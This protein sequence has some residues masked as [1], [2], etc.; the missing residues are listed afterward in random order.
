MI[1]PL[2]ASVA[3]LGVTGPGAAHVSH[4]VESLVVSDDAVEVMAVPDSIRLALAQHSHRAAALI[5]HEVEEAAV[6][7]TL[8]RHHRHGRLE[9]LVYDAHGHLTARVRVA[10]H[11]GRLD[12]AGLARLRRSLMPAI[13]HLTGHAAVVND[14]G[15]PSRSPAP[16]RP[17]APVAARGRAARAA[18][19]TAS[20][21]APPTPSANSGPDDSHDDADRDRDR[22][23]GQDN[24]PSN[25][26][27]NSDSD[28]DDDDTDASLGDDSPR[29]ASAP[30]MVAAVNL[31]LGVAS[32]SFAPGPA[33]VSAYSGGAVAMSRLE[34]E[35]RPAPRFGLRFL[36][37]HAFDFATAMPDGQSANTTLSRWQAAATVRLPLG[38]VA[39]EGLAGLGARHFTIDSKNL[40]RAPDGDYTYLVLGGRAHLTL[41]PTALTAL[42]ELQPVLGGGQPTMSTFG[43]ATRWALDIGAGFDVLFGHHL[44]ARASADYQ[45]FDWSWSQAG[46]RGAGGAVNGYLAAALSLGLRYDTAAGW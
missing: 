10:I 15:P 45:R 29:S 30:H 28:S 16:A 34:G 42:A 12:R 2:L 27:G 46:A 41:G 20:T 23:H 35:L 6:V 1:T 44:Y 4:Q 32:R 40:T 31:G 8:S 39:L 22:R 25:R 38:R 18:A 13:H 21:S 33:A 36:I 9:I 3:F 5:R 11:G 17:A 7:G 37:D 43:P 19:P 24:S 14:A 26:D